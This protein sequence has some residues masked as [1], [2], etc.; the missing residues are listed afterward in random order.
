[1]LA[2]PKAESLVTNF[3]SEWL[4]LRN[5]QSVNPA[6][7][8]FPNFDEN[9]RQAFRQE[10]E[11]FVGSVFRE[12][13]N[14]LDLLNANYTF[15]NERLARHYGIPNIYGSQFRRVTVTDEA[16]RG[17]L[18]QGSILTVTSYPTRT[19]PVLRGK[20]ILENV[21]GT[22]PP[23]PPP[24]VPALKESD[25]GGKITTVR[26]RLEE[27]RRNP[28][29]A[30]CHRVMDPLGFSLD[31]FDAIGQWRSKESGLPI[32]ASG[33]LADGTKVSGVLDLR[34]ALLQHPERFVGT[35]TEKLMTYAL[36]RGLEYYDMP[37]VRGIARDAAKNDD[38]FSS[39]VMG[40]VKTTAFQMKRAH[41]GEAAP[42]DTA[43]AR[44][45]K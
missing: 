2:D 11:M 31:N 33:Q 38:R 42:V 28:A 8:D 45:L 12:D 10:T 25:E 20:W 18:G 22:P 1:M 5:L 41:E 26:E 44:A 4:F 16:R 3:A 35:L 17:L 32:D 7:E 37:V 14:V 24:N 9:L 43:D 30:T 19:S 15:V 21:L 27:H 23:A 6:G 40:I 39:I 13:R 29:C 36:G 34:K